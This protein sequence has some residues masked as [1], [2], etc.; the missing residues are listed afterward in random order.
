MIWRPWRR[1]RELQLELDVLRRILDD[2]R[3]RDLHEAI[4]LAAGMHQKL[5]QARE[6]IVSAREELDAYDQSLRLLTEASRQ[7][8]EATN[9][10]A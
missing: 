2:E 6:E 10:A 1:C 8:A 5:V 9:A 3:R 7:R 4:T